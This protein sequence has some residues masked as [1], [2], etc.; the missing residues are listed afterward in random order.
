MKNLK[1]FL[2]LIAFSL[3]LQVNAQIS[4]WNG[5]ASQ[6]AKGDGTQ[7]NPY[8]I[9]SA[10]H[11]AYLSQQVVIGQRFAGQYF[12]LMTNINLNNLEWLPI[13]GRNMQGNEYGNYFSGIFDGNNKSISNL[14]ITAADKR[15]TGLFGY[16]ENYVSGITPEIRNLA[17]TSGTVNGKTSTAGVVGEFEGRIINC[18][19]AATIS[20]T[21]SGAGVVGFGSRYCEII[22]CTNNGNVSGYSV[23]GIVETAYDCLIQNCTNNGTINGDYASGIVETTDGYII[24]CTNNGSVTGGNIAGI[25]RYDL[26][27]G[28]IVSCCVNNGNLTGTSSGA[29]GGIGSFIDE[30]SSVISNCYNT[31]TL[32]KGGGIVGDAEKCRIENCYNVGTISSASSSSGAIVGALSNNATVTNCHYL[33]T[34]IST[35]NG[36]GISQ[37]AANMKAQ[38]FVTTLNASQN[39]APWKMGGSQNNGYPILVLSPYIKTLQ[40]KNITENSATLN[41]YIEMG[42]ES[43]TSQGF[44][45]KKY[46]TT[47]YTTINVSGNS[48]SSNIS[49]EPLSGYLFQAFATTASGTFYGEELSFT[50]PNVTFIP[51]INITDVPTIAMVATTLTL[52]GTVIPHNATNQ[53]IVWSIY[54]AGSTGA[55]INGNTFNA[56]TAGTVIITATIANG[57]ATG[58][59]YTQ[60][61]EITVNSDVSITETMQ[62]ENKQNVYPNPTNT[63]I[64]IPYSVNNK[65]LLQIININGQIMETINLSAEESIIEIDVSMYKSGVYFYKYDSFIGKFIINEKLIRL[66]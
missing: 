37:T 57:I 32:N 3:F 11:L 43:I 64:N 1:L 52:A 17:V 20:C 18:S 41:G 15:Y 38:S 16:V 36:Y 50:T 27:D 9:E 42:S 51:V 25:V 66:K 7:S 21:S 49:C 14:K 23:G 22:K 48:L 62:K 30:T 19:N 35:N 63:V 60:N 65:T 24:N 58:T 40:A 2:G 47:N 44:R 46:G 12:K 61:F 10:E 29:V 13:G 56:T 53:T 39:P 5:S 34:C 55:I 59:N 28:V 54:D 45:Y 6:W 26:S 31:G 4:T 8:L 33:N